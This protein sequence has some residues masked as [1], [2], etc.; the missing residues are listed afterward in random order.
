MKIQSPNYTQSPNVLFDEIFK[1]LKEGEL[2]IVLVLIRQTFGWHKEWDRIC[3]GMLANKSGMERKSVQRSLK[4]LIDKGVVE[5]KRYGKNGKE[6]LYFRLVMEEIEA[7][8]FDDDEITEEEIQM[9]S[10]NSYLRPK[11]PTPASL[12]PSTCVPKTPTKETIQ[13]KEKEIDCSESPPPEAAKTFVIKKI[14]L[15]RFEGPNLELSHD[16][17]LTLIVQNRKDWNNSEIEQLWKILENFGNPVRDLMKFCQTTIENLRKSNISKEIKE[18]NEKCIQKTYNQ[19]NTQNTQ[20]T[21]NQSSNTKETIS[22][23]DTS[24][25]PLANWKEMLGWDKKFPD[26]CKTP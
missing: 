11:V 15:K 7:E 5:Q 13:N 3:I 16:D 17:L 23:V 18:K 26:L 19:V 9:L 4:S 21:N 2:R 1:T 22:K 14:S 8:K 6:R 20:N 25:R 24:E 10:N 12:D